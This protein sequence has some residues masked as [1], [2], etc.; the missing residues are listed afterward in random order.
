VSSYLSS[1]LV[2]IVL[3][4]SKRLKHEK[5]SFGPWTLGRWGLPVNLFAAGYGLI[6]V[7]FTFFPPSVPISAESMNYS[8]V[9]YVGVVILGLLYY[10]VKGREGYVAPVAQ[11]YPGA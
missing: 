6:T 10:V 5:I 3:L 1:Y 2:P 11:M 8:S 4:I 7:V 9:V